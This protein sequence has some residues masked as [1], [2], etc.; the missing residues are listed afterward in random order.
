[1]K[2]II[3]V[4]LFFAFILNARQQ[5]DPAEQKVTYVEFVNTVDANG[6][7][8]CKE[9]QRDEEYMRKKASKIKSNELHVLA[10]SVGR[11]NVDGSL[12][13][14][15]TGLDIILRG[16]A[17]LDANP[18][19]AAAFVAAAARWE[20][21]LMNPITVTIDVDYGTTRFGQAWSSSNVLGSTSSA[22]F[23]LTTTTIRQFANSLISTNPQYSNIYNNIPDTLYNTTA[24]VYPRPSG[25][26]ANLQA[27]GIRGATET[28]TF[29]SAPSIGFNSNFT[30][31]LD[32]SDGISGGQ[33]DF[34]A[35][36]VHEIGHALGFVSVIGSTNSARPWDIFRFRPGIVK[37]T[38]TFK[39]ATR[40]LTPGPSATGG[41]QVF[42]DGTREWEVSTATGSQT[43][44]DG[45]QASH[46]RADEQRTSF[47]LA[48]R[49]IGI[50]DPTVASGVR[51]TMTLADLKA[52]SIIGWQIDFGNTINAVEEVA[53]I[54]DYTSPNSIQLK[55]KNPLR[56]FGGQI[57]TS[58]KIVLF[59]DGVKIKEILNPVAGAIM[60]YT[61]SNLVQYKSYSYR[62]VPVHSASNDSGYNKSFSAMAGGSP[63]PAPG[64]FVQIKSNQSTVYNKFTI[65]T[66][67][68]DQTVL[69][70][71]KWMKLYRN[72]PTQVNAGDS[73]QLLPTDTGKTVYM[74]D[75][76]PQR[77]LNNYSF[78]ASFV[79][80]GS[81]DAEGTPVGT[82]TTKGGTTFNVDYAEGFEAT[83]TSVVSD[84]GWDSTNITAHSGTYSLGLL[85][86]SNNKDLSA[87]IPLV[88]GNG[89][90]GLTFWSVCRIEPNDSALVQ[91]SRNRGKS[92]TTIQS[93]N[94]DS[95]AE[96]KSGT[97][98]WF[99]SVIP[100]TGYE[101]DTV[102]V[103][104][105]LKSNGSLSSFGWLID[106]IV[107]SP[108]LTSVLTAERPLP[109]QYNLE[110]NY[111]NPFNPSTRI[112][113]AVKDFGVVQIKVYDLLGK[114]ISTLVNEAKN[115]GL[116]SVNFNASQL[117]S[118]VYFYQLTVNNFS[119]MR[120][121]QLIK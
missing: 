92:W 35:V 72:T 12:M 51:E 100:L 58:Y 17:Q 121:M 66:K 46:W 31:D 89:S 34:D 104:F 71:L 43:G 50:M 78:F 13:P 27:I 67:H 69:H 81:T 79:G 49:F 106:D 115:P 29:G 118:G 62:F 21:K 91:I 15:Q 20:E 52:L 48:E 97:N 85:N 75:T 10:Q 2:Q 41:D 3:T 32:P 7:V 28:L 95:H 33:T 23:T 53:G 22:V 103:R 68:E 30:F 110:Q 82:P 59:R 57:A 14:N 55:W 26:L 54:S 45:N 40:V 87:Y 93:L 70:N 73:V 94:E 9:Y 109:E 24:V 84:D 5:Y 119:M 11:R 60:T 96:W 37:D 77:F 105:R 6:N 64:T 114:E 76:P 63:R 44:G 90:P 112:N 83:R 36:A 61:D 98:T 4:M 80:D 8:Q 116:Y 47:P 39:S 117:G 18:A 99:K 88:R 42:W 19:A 102:L 16:T 38:I 108:V 86:Y 65:P 113:Y 1:M 74:I 25:T 111:P 120:K 56:F 107:L 101:T